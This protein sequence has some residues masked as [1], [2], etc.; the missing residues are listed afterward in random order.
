MSSLLYLLREP[1]SKLSPALYTNINQEW[2][3]VLIEDA[4]PNLSASSRNDGVSH[5]TEKSQS[6]SASQYYDD[7]LSVVVK[8]RKVITL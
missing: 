7:L 6:A 4:G 5:K 8:A 1:V 3:A 2:T